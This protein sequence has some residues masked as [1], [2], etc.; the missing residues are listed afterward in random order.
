MTDRKL[1]DIAMRAIRASTERGTVL[2]RRY[3]CS[4]ALI[5]LVRSGRLHA[6]DVP[7]VSTPRQIVIAPHEWAGSARPMGPRSVFEVAQP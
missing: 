2:A 7:D 3:G 4:T 5:S 1:S 6:E